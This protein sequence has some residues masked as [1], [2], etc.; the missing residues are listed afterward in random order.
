MLQINFQLWKIGV[1]Y[2]RY[3]MMKEKANMPKELASGH[4]QSI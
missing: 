4:I 1:V 3:L 2:H